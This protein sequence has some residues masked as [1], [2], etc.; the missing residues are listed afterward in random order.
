MSAVR[1]FRRF[2]RRLIDRIPILNRAI[3]ASAGYRLL[4]EN[5]ARAFLTAH[6]G[7]HSKS[8]ARR[9]EKAYEF[10]LAQLCAGHPRV[11]FT[12]AAE[13]VKATG[14]AAPSLL[15][16]GCGNGYYCEVFKL[17]A[18][19][20]R[21]AGIDFSAAMV[22]SAHRRYPDFDFSVG[23]ATQLASPDKSIDIV[24]NGVSLMHVLNYPQAISEAARVARKYVILHS[25]PVFDAHETVYLSKYA[26]GEPVVEIVFDRRALENLLVQNG[27][28]ILKV[29]ESIS[30]DVADTVGH[31]SHCLTYL[32]EIGSYPASAET[33]QSV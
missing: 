2:V 18:P 8:S 30:Y 13:A 4:D 10:L 20:I 3:L 31:H 23:D 29:W 15:E 1:K 19:G 16:V 14:L 24:F 6:N 25:V 17:L 28:R 9:Q 26:Y 7:W 5:G 22:E 12:V 32:A 11:D 21:Y 33:A 27:M